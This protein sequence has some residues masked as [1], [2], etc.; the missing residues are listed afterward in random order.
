MCVPSV[1]GGAVWVRSLLLLS[2]AAGGAGFKYQTT[3]ETGQTWSTREGGG[4]VK[5]LLDMVRHS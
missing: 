4:G 1:L 2:C 5:F 3:A